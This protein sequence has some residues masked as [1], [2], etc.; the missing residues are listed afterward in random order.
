VPEYTGALLAYLSKCAASEKETAA[1]I[2]ALG[3]TSRG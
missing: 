1:Q 3:K 2:A